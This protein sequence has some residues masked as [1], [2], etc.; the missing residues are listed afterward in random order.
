MLPVCVIVAANDVEILLFFR[1][2]YNHNLAP[3]VW[4]QDTE[5]VSRASS[6]PS[7]PSLK[8]KG[9]TVFPEQCELL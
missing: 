5:S 7:T 8:V 4:K 3:F 6:V 1:G 9:E 2:V